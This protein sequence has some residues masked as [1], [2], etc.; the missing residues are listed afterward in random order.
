MSSK[1]ILILLGAPGSGKGTQAARLARELE[2]PHISTGD[3]FRENIKDQT[4][5]GIKA[6]AFMNKGNLVPDE[7]VLDMLFDRVSRADCRKG[8]ILD[9]F[10]RRISQADA[11]EQRLQPKEE[12]L[13]LNLLV[14]DEKIVQR[15]TG[16]LTCLSCGSVFHE[17]YK[18]P[19]VNGVCDQCGGELYER[20]DDSEEVV[21]QRLVVYQE[22]TQPL[23]DYYKKLGVL[24][25]ID[26][27]KA[28]ELVF[29]QLVS[30]VKE[31]D[32]L[33]T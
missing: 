16:R 30:V 10:P 9:G 12:V 4:E 19:Q 33:S 32:R 24:V 14:P 21:R 3:L 13:A 26:G 17:V 18:P 22:E 15:L 7:L 2:I 11:F 23:I 27:V 31:A 29:A 8:Y 28:P 6:Q 1:K 25:S 20:P 5:L